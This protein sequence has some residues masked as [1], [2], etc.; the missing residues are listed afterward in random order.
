MRYRNP[1]HK[2]TNISN[3]HAFLKLLMLLTNL[4][5]NNLIIATKETKTKTRKIDARSPGLMLLV[6]TKGGFAF[7]VS[8]SFSIS[9]YQCIFVARSSDVI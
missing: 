5:R 8:T 3:Q 4:T 2:E 7:P 9:G 6:R 1:D